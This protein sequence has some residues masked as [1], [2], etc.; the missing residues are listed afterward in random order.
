MTPQ[1][2]NGC[3]HMVTFPFP[4]C[5]PGNGKV[6]NDV[7]PLLCGPGQA[8]LYLVN[9]YVFMWSSTGIKFKPPEKDSR[10]TYRNTEV[11]SYMSIQRTWSVTV[12]CCTHLH[13]LVT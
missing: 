7:P 10:P 13:I 6:A 1:V 5:R 3:T 11:R 9:E 2:T 4:S 12:T 8:E